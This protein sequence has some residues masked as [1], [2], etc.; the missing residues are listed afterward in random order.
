METLTLP[1]PA[2]SLWR[3]VRDIIHGVPP[4]ATGRVVRPH[5]G[6]GTVLAARLRHRLSTDIDVFLPGRYSLISLAQE[7]EANVIRRL[8]GTAE[9]VSGAR[10]KVALPNGKV[11]L[12]IVRPVPSEGQHEAWI[13]GRREMVLTN[14]QIL[15]GKLDRPERVLVRD[16][17][18]VLVAA[19]ADPPAL[20]TAASLLAPQRAAAVA[21]M[22]RNADAM[23]RSQFEA[24][25]QVLEPARQLDRKT[26]GTR[27]AEALLDYRYRRI[28][29]EVGE[30]G[31]AIRKTIG[32]GALPPERYG[33]DDAERGVV[34][35]GIGG[36]LNNH[37]PVDEPYLM[38][39]IR[40]A[41]DRAEGWV[42]DSQDPWR[43]GGKG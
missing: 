21:N 39:R 7:N 20:A 27:A 15:R 22:W 6:G 38:Q 40:R 4:E 28:L 25:V 16:V 14:A 24:R 41:R 26:L 13:D 34:V 3:A 35:S 42:F 8:G 11:D 43:A 31:L 37:G 1:E 33:P 2:R 32:R 10:I 18:D 29:I 12:S 36:Y 30:E 19:E 17:V 23:L 9:S 5:L